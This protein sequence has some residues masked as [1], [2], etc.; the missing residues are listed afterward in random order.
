MPPYYTHRRYDMAEQVIEH[1]AGVSKV[2]TTSF[3][4]ESS[5]WLAHP[6]D[7]DITENKTFMIQAVL[8]KGTA[9]PE[10]MIIMLHGLN[11][12]SWAK[13]MSWAVTLSDLTKFAVLMMPTA[14]HIDRAPAAWISI[15]N[16]KP[17]EQQRKSAAA[18]LGHSAGSFSF[19]NAAVSSRID[20]HPARFVTSGCQTMDDIVSLVDDT[21]KGMYAPLLEPHIPVHLFSYSL[22][23]TMAQALLAADEFRDRKLFGASSR[24]VFFC[25]GASLADANPVSPYILDETAFRK[26]DGFLKALAADEEDALA[27]IP[28]ALREDL[29][30]RSL[31][32]LCEAAPGRK[33]LSLQSADSARR[34]LYIPMEGDEVYTPS[35]VMKACRDLPAAVRIFRPEY[36]NDH[37]RPFPQGSESEFAFNTVFSE[38]ASWYVQ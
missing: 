22:G 8:P 10:G 9:S 34:S 3:M 1:Q 6:K 32:A 4:R 20:E 17:L 15:R 2:Y 36:D 30:F 21:R 7:Q 29:H 13:Y 23:C 31:Q 11:E 24:M 19:V 16:M 37:V 27:S 25:G 18:R 26:L 5:A 33:N 28:L 38:A 14:F 35:A 12:R